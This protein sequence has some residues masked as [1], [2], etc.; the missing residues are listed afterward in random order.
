L[1]LPFLV[2]NY[3]YLPGRLAIV[4]CVWYTRLQMPDMARSPTQ[5]DVAAAAR[6]PSTPVDALI[7]L[8]G[9]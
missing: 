7:A 2:N 6:W 5:L 1:A 8:A 4:N 3:V 9:A